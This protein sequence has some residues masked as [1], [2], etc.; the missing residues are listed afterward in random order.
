MNQCYYNED[1]WQ[2]VTATSAGQ[3]PATHPSKWRKIRLLSKWRWVLA[4]LTYAYL[5]AADG[6]TDKAAIERNVALGRE[7]QGLND[8][9][10][11]EECEERHRCDRGRPA[12]VNTG[13]TRP[14]TAGVILDDAYGLMNWD[15][16]E[17]D[18]REKADARRA[19]SKALQEVWEKWWW[20][21]LM[22]CQVTQFAGN[23]IDVENY[24]TPA[25]YY[26]P[27]DK[28]YLA[29]ND[30]LGE[31]AD[32][33]GNVLT[34][35]LEY[36]P[37]PWPVWQP[38]TYA[39]GDKV[40]HA[41][42]FWYSYADGNDDVPGVGVGWSNLFDADPA[43]SNWT[44]TL[45]DDNSSNLA[46]IHG[47][48]RSVSRHD[49]R[50]AANPVFFELDVTGDGTR[51]LGLTVSHPWVWSRRVTP[52]INPTAADFDATATYEATAPEDLVYDD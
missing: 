45:P 31:P 47:P 40:Q 18:D 15:V 30:S 43:G 5:L 6:Q 44:P 1:F 16:D 33:A 29:V 13:R 48:I 32:S 2:C 38:G 39:I 50:T 46:L 21:E 4:Q 42:K 14:V 10:A 24:P 17:L 52:I 11:Q 20:Q 27:T 7:Q 12:R 36:D 35:W 26:A 22:L 9:A 25:C 34:G 49:P 3:S 19:F 23:W 28:Y 37:A 51:V 41:G 8:L